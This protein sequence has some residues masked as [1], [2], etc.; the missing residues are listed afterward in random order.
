M[1]PIACLVAGGR[2]MQWT[3]S[4]RPA[5]L[6]PHPVRNVVRQSDAAHAARGSQALVGQQIVNERPDR[7]SPLGGIEV[8]IHVKRPR[9]RVIAS[10]DVLLLRGHA[11]VSSVD[12]ELLDL[13]TPGPHRG[14]ASEA[15]ARVI[16]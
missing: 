11:P 6:P 10:H 14:K 12:S 1:M 16:S 15:E 4:M 3:R 7:R 13:V 2:T 8:H 5:P 9:E